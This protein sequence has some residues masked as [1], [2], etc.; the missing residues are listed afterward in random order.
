MSLKSIFIKDDGS[1]KLEKP[2]KTQVPP[3]YSVP[4]I[5][6]S[7]QT[8]SNLA[9]VADDKFVT[10]LWQAISDN[11]I[12]GQ[13]YFEFKQA[14]DQMANI[15]IDEKTKFITTFAVF[16]GQ[17]C[18]KE[19]LISSID[20]YVNIIKKEQANFASEMESQL[21]E[22]VRGKQGQI[23][24]AKKKVE[25]LNKQIMEA[26]NFIVTASQEAQQEELKIQMT[27]A[28]F[29]QSAERVLTALTGDKNKINMYLQ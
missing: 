17:G 20:T 5:Q 15:P 9:G 16:S 19:A 26:N 18:K 25:E 29:N 7:Q 22:K 27:N 11:N 24:E 1:P 10:I 28:N 23:E 6:V 12:P 14:I 13:D 4:P 2:A 21:S 8:A 3:V